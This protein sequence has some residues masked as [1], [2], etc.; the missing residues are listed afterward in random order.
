MDPLLFCHIPKC[1]GTS[2]RAVIEAEYKPKQRLFVYKQEEL[3]LPTPSAEFIERF[4]R[5][6]RDI[7]IIYGH[8]AFGMHRFLDIPPVYATI[9]REPV[10]RVI[11][12]Y[13]HFGRDLQSPFFDRIKGGLSLKAFAGMASNHMTRTLAGVPAL[14]GGVAYDEKWLDLAKENVRKYFCVIGTVES[15]DEVLAALARRLAWRHHS[16]PVLN[17]KPDSPT[18][19]DHET[20]QAIVEHNALDIGL[21]DWVK[22][23]GLHMSVGQSGAAS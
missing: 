1:A 21:Y 2:F 15:M 11:S 3:N 22:S 6:R 14:P 19:I 10:A 7:Q 13:H 16:I 20:R 12:L 5:I 8:F 18:Q 4:Q 23:S 17:V 9:V